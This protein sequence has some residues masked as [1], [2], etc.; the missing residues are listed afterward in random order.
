M[1][2]D[3]KTVVA[4]NLTALRKNKNLTQSDVAT[5]LN[6]SDKS[7]SKWEHADSLPDI[8]ILAQLCEI[9]GVTLDY[10]VSAN[11]KEDIEKHEIHRQNHADMSYLITSMLMSIAVVYLL[12]AVLFVYSI[13]IIKSE[14]FWQAFI[15]AIPASALLLLYYNRKWLKNKVL[16]VVSQSVACWFLLISV[17]LQFLS[18][19]LW[20]IFILGIPIQVIILLGIRLNKK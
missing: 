1:D 7:V 8:S 3:I 15:W 10:L 20:L 17:Y 12:A 11:A 4:E 19:R 16:K 18:Y 5:M 13:L 6:Y 2:R 14:P 9:Y